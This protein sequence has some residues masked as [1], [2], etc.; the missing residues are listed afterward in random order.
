MIIQYL[1]IVIQ[2]LAIVIQSPP[3]IIIQNKEVLCAD[4]FDWP[5]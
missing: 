2:Y 4:R 5:A 3:A 1:A